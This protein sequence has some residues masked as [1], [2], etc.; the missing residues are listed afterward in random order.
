MKTSLLL[1]AFLTASASLYAQSTVK[2]VVQDATGK[3]ISFATVA[4]LQAPDSALVKGVPTDGSGRFT[5]AGVKTG[6]YRISATGVGYQ[7][8]HSAVFEVTRAVTEVAVLQLTQ[9]TQTLAEVQVKGQKPLF[10]QQMDRMVI[11]VQSS[12]VAAGSSA[13]DILERSPGVSVNRQNNVLSMLGKTGVM[14][15]IDGKLSRLPVEAIIQQLAGMNAGNIET[16]ELI[17]TPPAKYDAEGTAGLINI[18][19][20]RNG[21]GGA[22]NYGTNGSYSLTL[23]RGRF[24]KPGGSFRLN[25][26]NARLNLFADYSG[27]VNHYWRGGPISRE[28]LVQNN[29]L[30]SVME[31]DRIDKAWNHNA[32]VG[33][34]Y[35]LS[36]KTTLGGL[37]SGYSNKDSQWAYNET[38]IRHGD[39]LLTQI[40]T[41]DREVN[42]W[43]NYMGNGNLRHVFNPKQELT[44]DV[45]YLFY[46]NNNPHWYQFNTDYRSENRTVNEQINN[47]KETPLRFWVGKADFTQTVGATLKIETGVKATI[48]DLTNRVAAQQRVGGEWQPLANE[49][50]QHIRM[51]ENIGAAYA[52]AT[53][54]LNPKTKFQAGLRWE[55][56][57]T[58]IQT[59]A[60][61]PILSRWYGNFFPTL[62]LSRE[63]STKSTIQFSYS[64]RITRPT[65]GA[66][67]PF[68]TLLDPNSL[69]SGNVTLRPTYAQTG[70]ATF[71][72]KSSD[73]LTLEHT[74][75]RDEIAWNI[76]TLPEQNRQITRPENIDNS[77]LY[78]LLF[79]FPLQVASWWQAQNTLMGVRQEATTQM[80]GAVARRVTNYAQVNLTNT[81]KLSRNFSAELS[82][83]YQTKSL[84]GV[85][86]RRGFGSVNAGLSKKLNREQGVLSLSV[87]DIFLMSKLEFVSFDPVTNL[88]S[89]FNSRSDSRVVRLTYARSFGSQAVKAAG[90]RSTASEEERSRAGN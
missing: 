29:V 58:D 21:N 33:F 70:Q 37:L 87:S 86:Y 63:L 83:F 5:F 36:R 55:Y 72:F 44:V 16:I 6:R 65:F 14:V 32:K 34:D 61:Q 79:S 24:L 56:T 84:M 68:V 89:Q 90:K 22:T 60:G 25:H 35:T 10:E 73:V 53:G 28:F 38:K 69:F 13:L 18:V 19:T 26:R 59:V 82:G 43:Y 12:V 11:N 47:Q 80:D 41:H 77:R 62:M 49:F 39:R 52:N 57:H 4:L 3:G 54:Q 48:A 75:M 46:R 76:K 8:I 17:T 9:T 71:R 85:M 23:G 40:G 74:R 15:M 2:G 7:L 27:D 31:N 42:H 64:Q 81:I 30:S 66:L 45:D 50:T 67:A 51:G 1:L 20:K 78:S 88:E